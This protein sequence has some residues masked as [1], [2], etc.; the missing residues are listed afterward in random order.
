MPQV[1]T[2]RTK[3]RE[4]AEPADPESLERGVRQLLADKVSGTMVGLWLLVP[5]HLRLGTWDLLR[6]WCGQPTPRVEPRL[7]L[8][9]VHEA[10]LCLTGI[11]QSRTLSQ[12]GFE[13][14]NGLPFVATDAAMHYLLDAHNAA[15][16]QEL[17]VALGM[18]RRARGHFEG[19]LLAID[20]H[21]M[22]SFSKRQMR[23]HRKSHQ[24]QTPPAKVAQTFFVLDADTHQPLCLTTASASRTVSQAT[25]ELLKLAGRILQPQKTPA[26][27]LADS[28]HYTQELLEHCARLPGLDLLVPM[29]DQPYYR[30]AIQALPQEV[31]KPKWA[32]LA[33]ASLPLSLGEDQP[34]LYQLVQRCG[35]RPEQYEYKGFVCTAPRDGVEALITEFPKRWHVEEFFHDHQ[36]LGWNR[37]GTLNLNIRFGQMSLALLAQAALYQLRQRL[38]APYATWQARPLAKHLL[39]GLDGDIRVRHDT[40]V[41]TYYNAP[42]DLRAH[43]QDLPDKLQAEGVNPKIPWLYDF[44]LD[45]RFK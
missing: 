43:Y 29:P 3:L 11:R 2:H 30:K 1:Q 16:A 36:H 26:L 9:L 21:R 17:Q 28:E 14:A 41:V 42:E 5:E 15:Q 25:P 38:G 33:L 23:R 44:K 22:A 35:E 12:K 13:L 7:A 18:V 31:F 32:G 10:A 27:A 34:Q 45:F 8:Q 37:A 20:P 24:E 19:K 40:L 6:A 39:A 4:R